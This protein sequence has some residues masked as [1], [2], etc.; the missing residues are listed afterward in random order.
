MVALVIVIG[1]SGYLPIYDSGWGFKVVFTYPR[2]LL[3]R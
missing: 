3:H 2:N 1:V